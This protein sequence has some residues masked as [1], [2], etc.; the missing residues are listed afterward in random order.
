MT[1]PVGPPPPRQLNGAPLDREEQIIQ[2]EFGESDEGTYR[3]QW[4]LS[5]GMLARCEHGFVLHHVPQRDGVQSN[6]PDKSPWCCECFVEGLPVLAIEN[7]PDLEQQVI[8]AG[9][10]ILIR[11]FVEKA[12]KERFDTASGWEASF[13]STL[14]A[15]WE[16][17]RAAGRNETYV[18]R[19][20]EKNPGLASDEIENILRCAYVKEIFQN[21]LTDALVP[22][23]SSEAAVILSSESL[24][25]AN[26]ARRADRSDEDETPAK[27]AKKADL[28][29]IESRGNIGDLAEREQALPIYIDVWEYKRDPNGFLG[30]LFP[31][32]HEIIEGFWAQ[33]PEKKPNPVARVIGAPDKTELPAHYSEATNFAHF[34]NGWLAELGEL[35]GIENRGKAEHEWTNILLERNR[36]TQLKSRKVGTRGA[37]TRK[38]I[39]LPRRLQFTTQD[40]PT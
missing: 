10:G 26:S 4:T 27:S 35:D 37:A 1:L 7:P 17:V 38:G 8:A 36:K 31:Y 16:L 18:Q 22:A 20:R 28:G 19:L 2:K 23:R 30:H 24:D 14:A 25:E 32:L 15:K 33:H 21:L 3:P 13:I 40:S 29:S 5:N 12:D 34:Y 6:D 11:K 9:F 39:N